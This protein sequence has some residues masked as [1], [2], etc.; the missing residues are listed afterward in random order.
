MPLPVSFTATTS[1]PA[2]PAALVGAPGLTT[3]T[4]FH[5]AKCDADT[6]PRARE[7]TRWALRLTREPRNR[8]R[9]LLPDKSMR[10]PLTP[11]GPSADAGLVTTLSSSVS[12]KP[13]HTVTV[14][15]ADE[16]LMAFESTLRSTWFSCG[17]TRASGGG[18]GGGER[19]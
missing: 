6:E 5:T 10:L 16:Y 9:K 18:A 7:A 15:P 2:T 4:L 17:Q 14:A 12:M 11:F 13:A 19:E 3:R 1:S 8:L